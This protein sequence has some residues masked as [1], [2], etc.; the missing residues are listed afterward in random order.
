MATSS[1]SSSSSSACLPE[2]PTQQI[3]LL[4]PEQLSPV[5]QNIVYEGC[6]ANHPERIALQEQP[7]GLLKEV[8]FDAA[9]AHLRDPLRR[10]VIATTWW[11]KNER[12]TD[13]VLQQFIRRIKAKEFEC[14][15][16]G[17]KVYV[18]SS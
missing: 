7:E 2:T 5:A 4:D 14:L 9:L 3:A 8:F 11:L 15:S 6:I 12:E 16:C 10:E 1:T 17:K 13:R 18:L